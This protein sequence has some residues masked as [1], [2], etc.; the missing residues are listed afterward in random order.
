VLLSVAVVLV[1]DNRPLLKLALLKGAGFGFAAALILEAGFATDA[2]YPALLR[3][4]AM[5]LILAFP[6]TYLQ[7]SGSGQNITPI[8]SEDKLHE[9]R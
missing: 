8:S 9:L 2:M 3:L 7:D 5:M 4:I 1:L 6:L